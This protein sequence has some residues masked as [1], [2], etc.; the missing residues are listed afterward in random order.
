MIK[1]TPR[2][3]P[4]QDTRV[5]NIHQRIGL[6]EEEFSEIQSDVLYVSCRMLEFKNKMLELFDLVKNKDILDINVEPNALCKCRHKAKYHCVNKYNALEECERC[7]C[8]DFRR[9]K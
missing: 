4:F 5:R 3:G 2:E 9:K 8:L 1:K 6:I 7:L